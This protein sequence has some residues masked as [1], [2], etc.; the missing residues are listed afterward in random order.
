MPQAEELIGERLSLR[1]VGPEDLGRVQ[2]WLVDREVGRYLLPVWSLLPTARGGRVERLYTAPDGVHFAIVLRRGSRPIGICALFGI[3][4]I[5]ETAEV[6]IVI[7]EKALWG[8][9]YGPEALSLLL[10][11]AFGTLGLRRVFL[12]VQ[13]SNT[14][15]IRAYEKVGFVHE[16]RL[17]IAQLFFGKGAE[18]LV[19]G[20]RAEAWPGARTME[21]GA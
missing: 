19:M 18:I 4:W 2:Q 13:A 21:V 6:G 8:Q 5:G 20:L 11:H 14:R 10:D 3:D 9:G 16:G 12:H 15:A 1:P 17:R 7:G